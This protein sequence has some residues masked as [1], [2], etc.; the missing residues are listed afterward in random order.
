MCQSWLW[1]WLVLMGGVALFWALTVVQLLAE[2][3][4]VGQ[5]CRTD[6]CPAFSIANNGRLKTG[7]APAGWA[8]SEVSPVWMWQ[9]PAAMTPG[10]QQAGSLGGFSVNLTGHVP[11]IFDPA[12]IGLQKGTGPNSSSWISGAPAGRPS[13]PPVPEPGSLLLLGSG[14]AGWQAWKRMHDSG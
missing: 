6:T 12:K 13:G 14:W 2:P 8:F 5:S 7:A 3:L 4:P 9:A 10:I 1:R 11:V